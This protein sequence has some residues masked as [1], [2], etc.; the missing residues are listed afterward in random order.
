VLPYF[1]IPYQDDLPQES[2]AARAWLL[3]LTRG[4]ELAMALGAP[5]RLLL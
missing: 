5:V 3:D 1:Y 4:I 2:A